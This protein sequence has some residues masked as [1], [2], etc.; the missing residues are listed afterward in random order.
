LRRFGID[1]DTAARMTSGGSETWMTSREAADLGIVTEVTTW[2]PAPFPARPENLA[3][4]PAVACIF[5]PKT[6][7]PKGLCTMDKPEIIEELL[8]AVIP[9]DA[10][11]E[12]KLRE[13]I[14]RLNTAETELAAKAEEVTQLTEKVTALEGDL[15]AKSEEI[16]SLTEEVKAK[17]DECQRVMAK[18]SRPAATPAP[19]NRTFAQAL[20][21]YRQAHPGK[22]YD[23]A[24]CAVAK[25]HP[26]LYKATRRCK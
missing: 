21:E 4:F 3:E 6:L 25:A 1:S 20:A 18:L 10:A 12:E 5:P 16:A 24:F 26:E 13:V 14:D 9:G 23:S 8:E 2:E 7:H 22:S 19:K 17:G 11:P 15:T